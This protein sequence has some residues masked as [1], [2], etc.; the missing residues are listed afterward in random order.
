MIQKPPRPSA[1][2]PVKPIQPP[3]APQEA[4]PVDV[5]QLGGKLGERVKQF[6]DRLA[7]E[8]MP[9]VF[10]R[11]ELQNRAMAV[12]VDFMAAVMAF[13]LFSFLVRMVLPA[14]MA[15]LF[16][17]AA[18]AVAGL[19]ILFKDSLRGQ[20]PGKKLVGLRA[21]RTDRNAPV[22]FVTSAVRNWPLASLFVGPGVGSTFE[23]M[24]F[25]WLLV[26]LLAAG[27]LAL[28]GYETYRV[29]TDRKDGLRLGD[30]MAKT[31]VTED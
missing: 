13:F 17:A 14:T 31:R 15:G 19:F 28:V 4:P 11:P 27:S 9:E 24:P 30:V 2:R 3:A 22:D 5:G 16:Q 26:T 25:R 10:N 12:L 23:S 29:L 6:Q 18:A 7:K 1:A 8:P 20:S 21:V